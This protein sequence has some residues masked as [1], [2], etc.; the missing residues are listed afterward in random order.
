MDWPFKTVLARLVLAIAGICAAGLETGTAQIRNKPQKL[1][2][3]PQEKSVSVGDRTVILVRLLDGLNQ[4][5]AAERDIPVD[6]M[7]RTGDGPKKPFSKAVI[8]RGQSQVEVPLPALSEPG[9]TYLWARNPELLLGGGFVRV[10]KESGRTGAPESPNVFMGARESPSVVFKGLPD[11]PI[12][13]PAPPKPMPPAPSPVVPARP[14]PA[15]S[16]S[17]YQLALRYSPERTFLAN[18]KDPVTVHA[19]VIS[20]QARLPGF[21]INLFD[22][23]GRMLPKP[24]LIRPGEDE[25]TATLTYDH[26]GS[27]KVQYLSASPTLEV[28]GQRELEIHFGPPVMGVE[29]TANPREASLVDTADLVATL[30]DDQGKPIATHEPRVI[31]F[32]RTTGR[33]EIEK[34]EVTIDAGKAEARTRF[35]PTWWGASEIVASTPDLRRAATAVQIFPP[36]GLL[37]ISLAG[38]LAGAGLFFLKT[39]LKTTAEKRWRI[40]VGALAGLT[41]FWVALY[42]SLA[43]LSRTVVLNPFSVFIISMAGGWAG[44][45]IFDFVLDRLA[46]SAKADDE[47]M[48]TEPAS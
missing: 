5:L 37:G 21:R 14:K 4:P 9:L 35:T 42:F 43:G 30:V 23:S 6:I 19:F 45:R 20:D 31:S 3:R 7:K 32:T 27:V 22:G 47:D 33:G 38:G 41:L 10:K 2:V 48:K 39:T 36:W 46:P 25:A 40:P 44:P 34:Q 8:Q 17:T 18:G 15:K 24:L 29:L 12:A 16:A 13:L 28:D 1:E 11:S 26:V